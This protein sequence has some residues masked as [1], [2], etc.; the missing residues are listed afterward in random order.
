MSFRTPLAEIVSAAVA[1]S[2]LPE[3]F[4]SLDETSRRRI[5]RLAEAAGVAPEAQYA[6]MREAT[7]VATADDQIVAAVLASGR[8]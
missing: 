7:I 1:S 2:P 4:D 3:S 8:R 6:A 5:G